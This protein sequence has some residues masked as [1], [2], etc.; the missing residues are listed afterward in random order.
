MNNLHTIF[1]SAAAALG[2]ACSCQ[3]VPAA[4]A[5]VVI[6]GMSGLYLETS[7]QSRRDLCVTR[8]KDS[9]A[10]WTGTMAHWKQRNASVLEDL[11]AIAERLEG[12]PH[13]GGSGNEAAAS[14]LQFKLMAALAPAGNL[15]PLVDEQAARVCAQWLS[16]LEPAGKVEQA[17]PVLLDSARKLQPVTR[18]AR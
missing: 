9:Q 17:L 1:R 18:Q 16:D 10:A 11:R 4:G 5:S 8:F 12:A 3:A 13:P 6:S 15:A 14:L 7:I 2:L